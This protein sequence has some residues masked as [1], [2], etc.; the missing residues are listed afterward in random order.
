MP[1]RRA[2]ALVVGELCL[3]VHVT[4]P[5]A[6]DSLSPLLQGT[7]VSARGGVS[8][9]PGGTGWL[10]AD[11]LASSSAIL[12]LITATVGGDWAGDLLSASLR[13]R[14]FP[15]DGVIRAAG[16]HTDVVSVTSFND[17]SRLMVWPADK[18]SH[19][20]RAWD[21]WRIVGLVASH[22]VRFAW[23]SGY[24]LEDRGPRVLEA[25][26]DLFANLRERGIAIVLDLVPH[27]FAL[28]VGD[29]RWL[30]RQ[31][32]PVDVVVGEFATLVDLGFGQCPAPGEDV[33]SAML[34]C[35][36]GAASG[37]AGA[38]VQQR[39][40]G[41]VYLSVVAGHAAGEHVIS[42]PVPASGPRGIGDVLAVQAL[43]ALGFIP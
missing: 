29:L 18:V 42:R 2:A 8:V 41:D 16:H 27:D 22:D 37:R 5:S 28:K 23:V 6:N 40:D 39:T 10:F 32:G 13:D 31:A 12:P 38:V 3:D 9:L 34:G 11:A 26:R 19:K 21:W 4:L 24:L 35:A 20:V 33:R 36:R 1:T 15:G 7:D 30:D 14:Q 25:A 43:M 17:R